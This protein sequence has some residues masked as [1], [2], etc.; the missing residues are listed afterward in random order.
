[1]V[2]PLL[3]NPLV[4][5]SPLICYLSNCTRCV[6]ARNVAEREHAQCEYVKICFLEPKNHLD[7]SR[8]LR[9]FVSSIRMNEEI[10]KRYDQTVISLQF[11]F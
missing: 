7:C 2:F 10:V 1:M 9:T 5:D 3:I 8:F 11:I 4:P 6:F